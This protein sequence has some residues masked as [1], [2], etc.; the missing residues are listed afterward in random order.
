MLLAEMPDCIK[1]SDYRTGK[2]IWAYGESASCCNGAMFERL[3]PRLP[4]YS[5][6]FCSR[7]PPHLIC[8]TA[9]R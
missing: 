1:R 9:R 7:V 5:A 2:R 8:E 4:H 6:S 3:A